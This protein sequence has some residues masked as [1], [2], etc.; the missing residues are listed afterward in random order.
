VPASAR[1]EL[2]IY[3]GRSNPSWTL[4]APATADFAGLLTT[5]PTTAPFE[6]AAPLGYRGFVVAW[7][8]GSQQQAVIVQSGRV[9]WMSGQRSRYLSDSGRRLERWLRESGRAHLDLAVLSVVDQ[10]LGPGPGSS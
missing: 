2:D 4:A 5:L 9:K 10:A 7:Q 1:V 8:D 6:P 3:S